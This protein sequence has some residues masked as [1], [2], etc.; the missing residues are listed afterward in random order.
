VD[1]WLGMPLALTNMKVNLPLVGAFLTLVGYSVNDTIVIF[2]R[3]RENRGKYGDLS[4]SVVNSSINQTLSRTVLT[5]STVFIAVV[6]LYFFG[7]K[8]SSIHGLAFVMLFGTVVG[9]YSSIAIA[10]PILVMGDYLRKVYAWSYL[11]LA[12]GLAAYF[13]AIWKVAGAVTSGVPEGFAGTWLDYAWTVPNEFFGSPVAWSWLAPVILW[14]GWAAVATWASVCGAYGQPW[15]LVAKAPGAAK[16]VA[17][18]ALLAAPAAVIFGAIAALSAS[19]SAAP[20]WAGPAAVAML[21]TCP[22]TYAIYRLVWGKPLRK[23]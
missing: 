22:A 23:S 21:V 18:L 12:A 3:I 1:T 20:A 7:G 2:D 10:S 15:S 8:D 4:V 5:S 16:A 14:L 19:G 11:I 6:A 17:T 13:L 9:C